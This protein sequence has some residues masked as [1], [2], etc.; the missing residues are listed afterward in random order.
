MNIYR[1]SNKCPKCGGVE[2]SER[3]HEGIDKCTWGQSHFVG[4]HIHRTCKRCGYQWP[5]TPLDIKVEDPESSN[6]LNG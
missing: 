3:H 4:E 2:I 1:S 5:E 6:P